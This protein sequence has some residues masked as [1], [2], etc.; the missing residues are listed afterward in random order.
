MDPTDIRSQQV[1]RFMDVVEKIQPKAFVLENVKALGELDKWEAVRQKLFSRAH[2]LGFSFTQ[3]IVLNATDFGV[4][5]KRERM[6]FVGIREAGALDQVNGLEKYLAPYRTTAPKSGEI[7]K[8]LGKAGSLTNSRICRARITLATKPVMRK[9][10]YAGMLFNGA[11]RPIN[12]NDFSNTLPASMGG[13]KTPIVDED[14]IFHGKPSWIEE[15]HAK[16]LNGY[17]PVFAEA[18]ARLRRL[19]I[20]EA[21]RIQTFP[22]D[23]HF[24]GRTNSIY[25]QIGNAVPCKLAFAVGSATRDMINIAYSSNRIVPSSKIIQQSALYATA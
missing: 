1:F 20:D 5:Q 10:P 13:N 8:T 4:P 3:L 2:E 17:E 7:I 16:L 23:Y 6:F 11:G 15:Y 22:D 24:V 18:P 19:T 21:L 25:T 9:S 14:Q 12:P